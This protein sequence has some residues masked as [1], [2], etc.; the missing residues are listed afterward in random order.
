MRPRLVALM[1]V[2]AFSVLLA[3]P[4]AA[5]GE[6]DHI[7]TN[8]FVS[9]SGPT[10]VDV[11]VERAD[12][13]TTRVARAGASGV[14]GCSYDILAG[15]AARQLLLVMFG[16]D[17]ADIDP[18]LR[19]VFHSCREPNR[20]VELVAVYR[21]GDPITQVIVDALVASAY[22][23]LEIPVL[24][25]QSAPRGDTAA[26]FVARLESWL[27]V[28]ASSWVAVSRDVSVPGARVV[29][30]ATP[31]STRWRPGTGDHSIEC[32]G[33]G[34]AYDFSSTDISQSTG[35][36]YT[37]TASSAAQPDAAYVMALTVVWSV[38][39]VCEPACGTGLLPAF[40]ITSSRPVR[41]A[42]IQALNNASTSRS[43]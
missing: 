11:G 3:V 18:A 1:C 6:N 15:E 34:V 2:S 21:V 14:A 19:Y 8:P 23:H 12:S 37:Y 28:A 39:W 29:A 26:P 13:A 4:P 35:C 38:S 22:D 16:V 9:Q 30:T 31:V 7:A 25:Q 32:V 27:W 17:V 40:E 24:I 42:E 20:F 10:T 33:G 5:A 43:R 41:V 36:S